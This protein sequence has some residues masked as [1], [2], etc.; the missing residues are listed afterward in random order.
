[1]KDNEKTRIVVF[2][3]YGRNFRL[4][5]GICKANADV[6]N[7]FLL[8]THVNCFT[9]CF[10]F[11]RQFFYAHT[12]NKYP[13]EDFQLLSHRLFGQECNLHRSAV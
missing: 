9:V 10:D 3:S 13:L 11:L 6:N 7:I 4:C 12:G 2:F 8:R 5:A 1:M